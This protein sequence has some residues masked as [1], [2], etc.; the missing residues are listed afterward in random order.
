MIPA[1]TLAT[2]IKSSTSTY[3]FS[4][5]AD[6][7]CKYKPLKMGD[8]KD[9]IGLD[10]MTRKTLNSDSQIV[11]DRENGIGQIIVAMEPGLYRSNHFSNE[12][13]L[14]QPSYLVKLDRSIPKQAKDSH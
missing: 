4:V 13:T 1:A 2:K 7:F 10:I 8:F 6:P 3:V 11:A 14:R 5:V 12:I 9:F